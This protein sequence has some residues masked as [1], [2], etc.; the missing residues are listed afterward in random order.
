MSCFP[1]LYAVFCRLSN[2]SLQSQCLLINLAPH[3]HHFFASQRYTLP[4]NYSL[5]WITGR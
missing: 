1:L 4:A 2:F 5:K 3:R